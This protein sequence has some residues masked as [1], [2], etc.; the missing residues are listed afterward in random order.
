MLLFAYSGSSITLLFE[1]LNKELCLNV[2]FLLLCRAMQRENV[3]R[4]VFLRVKFL[5]LMVSIFFICWMKRFV[6]LYFSSIILAKSMQARPFPRED[7][8][9]AEWHKP[10]K[11]LVYILLVGANVNTLW[12]KLSHL[13]VVERALFFESSVS[14]KCFSIIPFNI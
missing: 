9:T 10:A 6:L 5:L 11:F 7:E 1:Q 3:Y 13:L 8:W 12:C 4:R 14:E 2:L